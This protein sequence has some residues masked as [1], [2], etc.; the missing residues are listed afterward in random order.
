M[1]DVGEEALD[2]LTVRQ[3][4][5]RLN[6]SE[7]TV[8]RLIWA[9]EL[10]ALTVGTRSRRITPEAVKAYEDQLRAKAADPAA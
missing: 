7:K 10:K 3:V 6:F 4:A 5:K 9:G 8:Y 1:A 2:W